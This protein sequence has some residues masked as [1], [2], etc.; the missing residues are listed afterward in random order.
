M[1]GGQ[2]EQE[3]NKIAL[4]MSGTS[5]RHLQNENLGGQEC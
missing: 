5:G 2:A 4:F 3:Q 1:Q